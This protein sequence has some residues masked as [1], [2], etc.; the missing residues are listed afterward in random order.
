MQCDVGGGEGLLLWRCC[1]SGMYIC[2]NCNR[3]EAAR[4]GTTARPTTAGCC[5]GAQRSDPH[6]SRMCQWYGITQGGV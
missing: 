1:W 2:R 6:W 3:A 5:S 4:S